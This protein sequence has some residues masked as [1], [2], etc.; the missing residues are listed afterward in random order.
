MWGMGLGF[1]FV[2]ALPKIGA[3]DVPALALG[4]VQRKAEILVLA[5]VAAI[6][7]EE[8]G[9][10]IHGEK[11]EARTSKLVPLL[12]DRE[13]PCRNT[14]HGAAPVWAR[15]TVSFRQQK[16]RGFQ[17]KRNCMPVRLKRGSIDAT[18]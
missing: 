2:V 9:L 18:P 15:S 6:A 1:R 7:A 12:R 8:S 11:K 10:V 3:D 16:I 4:T 17:K 5:L 14:R 13:A